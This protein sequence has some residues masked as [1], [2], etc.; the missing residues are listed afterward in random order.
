MSLGLII[1][2]E[3]SDLVQSQNFVSIGMEFLTHIIV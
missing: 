1:N 3:K 2:E